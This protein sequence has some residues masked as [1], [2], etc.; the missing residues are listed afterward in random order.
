MNKVLRVLLPVVVVLVAV[1]LAAVMVRSRPKAKR[2]KP[3]QAAMLVDVVV[4]EPESRHVQVAGM[5]TVVPEQSVVLQPQVS[6]LIVAASPSL[7]AGGRFAKGE[8]I[9]RID[10]RDYRLRLQQRKSE[11]TRARFESKV[12]QGR[13]SVA[14][15][16]WRLLEGSVQT[17]SLGRSLALRKPH[18]EAASARAQAAESAISQAELDLS[19]TVL[20]APFNCVVQRRQ[21]SVGQLVS[22]QSP[23]ATLV[24]TDRFL[25]QVS[26]PVEHLAWIAVPG[27]NAVEG[28]TAKVVQR[29]GGQTTSSRDGRVLRLLGEL[30]PMGRMARLSL[31]IAGPLDVTSTH[32]EG[33][34]QQ[35]ATPLLLGAYVE[36]AIEGKRIESVYSIARSALHDDDVIWLVGPGDLLEVRAVDVVWRQRDVVL[37][38]NGLEPGMRLVVSHLPSPVPGMKLRVRAAAVESKVDVGGEQ[39]R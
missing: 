32:D 2:A 3:K 1:A 29:V 30:D 31:A 37:V 27:L 12:E 23:V 25:V 19:R 39:R 14:E 38:A 11:V 17:T 5:G 21:A 13:A 33:Q 20:R 8:V 15:R 34:K 4:L 16:E 36:V 6:G 18:Q 28:A 24:A 26:V 22:P 35:S 9:A 7:Q 10:D